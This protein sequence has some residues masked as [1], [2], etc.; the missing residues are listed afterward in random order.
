[1]A[2][3]RDGWRESSRTLGWAP[4]ERHTSFVIQTRI[5]LDAAGQLAAAAV[6]LVEGVEGGDHTRRQV[7][8][9]GFPGALLGIHSIVS[10]DSTA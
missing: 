8:I 2:L 4:A 1:L 5:A 7:L 6:L 3:P 10:P 9:K